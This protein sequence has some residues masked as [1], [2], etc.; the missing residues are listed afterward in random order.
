[1]NEIKLNIDFIASETRII[2]GPEDIK[3]EIRIICN[4]INQRISGIE[5]KEK[6]VLL[7]LIGRDIEKFDELIQKI[8]EN[9]K[10]KKLF[11]LLITHVAD[12]KFLFL[13]PEEQASLIKEMNW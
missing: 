11:F 1:M 5:F 7:S 10:S 6:D 8:E 3:D 9:E 13:T 4:D 12:I 2:E